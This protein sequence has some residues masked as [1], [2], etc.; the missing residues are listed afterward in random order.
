MY[1]SSAVNQLFHDCHTD[2]NGLVPWS[3]LGL[4]QGG[5]MIGTVNFVSISISNLKI[6]S[7][8]NHEEIH[9]FS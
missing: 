9:H 1:L 4:W 8:E 2:L 5:L 7:V 6:L 3:W